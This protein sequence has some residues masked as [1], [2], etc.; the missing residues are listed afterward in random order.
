MSGPRPRARDNLDPVKR[1]LA[2]YLAGAMGVAL[3]VLVGT[4]VLGGTLG[5]FVVLAVALVS[6][7]LLQRWMLGRLRERPMSDEDRLLQT[8]AGGLLLLAVLFA[9]MAAVVL[10]VG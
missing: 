5:P 2:G 10:T 9:V 3:L 7:G 8:A 6:G 1:T 4:A